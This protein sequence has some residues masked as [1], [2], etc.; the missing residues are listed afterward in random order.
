M[1]RV[2]LLGAGLV[3]RPLVRYL[4]ARPGL[5]L[6]I[7]SR[8]VSK[9]EALLEGHAQG[10]ALALLVDDQAALSREVAAH[11]LTISL[12]PYTHHVRVARL[13]LQ[14]RRHMVT[15]SY[16][17]Q[18]MRALDGEAQSAG[19]TIL[20]EIGVDPGID[21]MS[22]MR[23]IDDVKR[24]GG[25]VTAFSS[26][27]GGLPA[28]EANTNP[29]GYKFS[30]SPRGVLMAG[31]NDGRFLRGGQT[32]DIP[33]AEL[34]A[35]YEPVEVPDAGTF[36][37]YTN[38][39]CLGYIDL[40]GLQGIADMFRGT[41]RYPGW[42][43][44]MRAFARLGYL[45]DAPRPELRGMTFRDL[46]GLL[47][48]EARGPADPAGAVARHLGLARDADP[49]RRFEWLG[50]FGDEPLPDAPSIMDAMVARMLARMAYAP[51]ERDML[52]MHHRFQARFPD[53]RESTTSTMVDFGI[54]GGDTSMART[55]S[56]PAAIATG[57]ILEGRITRRG[58]LAPV[59][60]EIYEPVLA[61]LE[62]L[63]ITC[64]ERTTRS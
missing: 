17:S 60:A 42:C 46:A 55:V 21:H 7:A 41:L 25:T 53:H 36:E 20:N 28:P 58:V 15:T 2:L 34:F 38:R 23:V 54:P 48:P 40:Y 37:G 31:K 29:W 18:E 56:L 26:Y 19:L 44:T 3:T 47:V 8:T 33:G 5:S 9:A 59:F 49:I 12:L 10:R 63:Q 61:E 32:I 64:R 50:L 14:H 4:L 24:R 13:C 1:A 52:V 27:C 62:T 51:G 11:D 22:A 6:T 39:D 35:H 57:M 16:I 43:D 30:W 45:D